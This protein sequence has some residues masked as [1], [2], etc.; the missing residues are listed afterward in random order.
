MQT[1]RTEPRIKKERVAVYVSLGLAFAAIAAI[2]PVMS[3][4]AF[5]AEPADAD[6]WGTVTSQRATTEGDIGE[7]SSALEQGTG[8]RFGLPNIPIEEL[9]DTP[10]HPSELGEFLDDKDEIDATNCP[11]EPE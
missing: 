7:H 4:T 5:A 8:Q 1:I 9:G 6:C 11:G 3:T 2:V 10:N